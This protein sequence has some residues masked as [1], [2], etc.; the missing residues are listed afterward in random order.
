MSRVSRRVFASAPSSVAASTFTPFTSAAV[1]ASSSPCEDAIFDLSRASS[2]SSAR[3]ESCICAIFCATSSGFVFSAAA[4]SASF[5][6]R[7]CT[8]SS[9]PSPVTASTRRMPAA[10][11][12][13]DTILKKPMSPVRR[14]CVPPQSSV[15]KSPMPRTRTSSPYF[16]PKSAI[17]PDLIASSYFMIRA[18]TS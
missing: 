8:Q 13:S 7:A 9:A 6:S 18:L 3:T 12:V 15:E 1:S 2:R 10:M 16:S 17:A 4:A 11:P 5:A 14:T